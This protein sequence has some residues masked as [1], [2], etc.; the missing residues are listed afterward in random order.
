MRLDMHSEARCVKAHDVEFPES[1]ICLPEPGGSKALNVLSLAMSRDLRRQVAEQQEEED[2][3][4]DLVEKH[5]KDRPT[6]SGGAEEKSLD[7]IKAAA[8]GVVGQKTTLLE[9]SK[10]QSRVKSEDF[11]KGPRPL[12][13]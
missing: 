11:G 1:R 12:H 2:E 4:Q 9:I 6:P 7:Q 10:N 8:W 13:G 3:F 5:A